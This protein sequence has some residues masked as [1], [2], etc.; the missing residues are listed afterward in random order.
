MTKTDTRGALVSGAL[1]TVAGVGWLVGEAV[2]ASAFPGYD[3]ATNYISDLG[4]PDVG[5]F[6]GRSIDSPLHVLMNT[7]FIGQGVLFGIAAVLAVVVFRAASRRARVATAVL[8]VVHLFGMVLVGSFHGSQTSTDG[9]TI[10]F[11]VLGAAA[12]ITTG[13]L[14]A[15]TAG[16]GSRAPAAYRIASVALGIV[17]LVSLVMLVVDSSSTVIEVLPD[18]VWERAS[19]YTIVAWELLTGIALLVAGTRRLRTARASAVGA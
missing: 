19:V 12:A 1:W 13:N 8:A 2:S 11:H 4:V 10:V 15:I 5:T 16:I 9:G 7:T 18:G 6:Q 17:G 3:Y 14:V